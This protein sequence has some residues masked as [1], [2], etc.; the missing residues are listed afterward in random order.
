MK[1]ATAWIIGVGATRFQRWPQE[2]HHALATSALSEALEDAGL[3]D[4]H[5]IA[6][7]W[8]GN[9]G[10]HHWGQANI[11]GQVALDPLISDGLLPAGVPI[12][13]VEAGCATGSLALHDAVAAVQ[14]GRVTAALAI[15]VEKTFMPAHPERMMAL[16]DGALDQLSPERWR[17][18]YAEAAERHGLTYRP[19]PA[20]IQLLDVCAMQANWHMATYGTTSEQ[21]AASA[22]KNHTHAQHNPRAQYQHPMTVAEVLADKAVVGPL[23]RSMCAPISDGAAAAIVVNEAGLR[24]LSERARR[25]AVP[26]LACAQAGGTWDDLGTPTAA[27][28]AADAAYTQAQIAPQ[29]VDVVEL[30]DATSFAEVHLSEML[31][32]CPEGQG[33]VY[34]ASGEASLGGRRPANLSGGLV[35]KGHPLGASGLAMI[36]ELAT[37]LRGE[38]G[39][40]QSEGCEIGLAENGGGLT[41]FDVASCAVT[42]LG[43]ARGDRGQ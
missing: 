21:I 40:R 43:R 2:T 37:Q 25:R 13:N 19:H 20:R 41:G 27:R 31:R 10:M 14:S 22:A 39:A 4:G 38:A 30:H 35:S 33:G 18:F 3:E 6:A 7:V 9:C 15:G 8:F 16:F 24:Q 36:H 17:T 12:T 1:P 29:Q 34:V 32:L 23:T 28:R 11:R 42:L 26:I 5:G